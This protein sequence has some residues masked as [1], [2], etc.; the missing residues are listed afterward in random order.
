MEVRLIVYNE[1][2]Q[3]LKAQLEDYKETIGLL[4]KIVLNS[5]KQRIKDNLEINSLKKRIKELER[6]DTD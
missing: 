3:E 6:N 1:I 2:I 4:E 5:N